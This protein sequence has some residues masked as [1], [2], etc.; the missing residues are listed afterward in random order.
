MLSRGSTFQ[1]SLNY[2]CISGRGTFVPKLLLNFWRGV[3][4][5]QNSAL[6]ESMFLTLWKKY[7]KLACVFFCRITTT[8]NLFGNNISKCSEC[9]KVLAS[10]ENTYQNQNNFE[11]IKKLE[12]VSRFLIPQPPNV[13]PHMNIMIAVAIL[14]PTWSWFAK[15]LVDETVG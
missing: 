2:C 7:S 11:K 15:R 9:L 14:A 1:N 6:L 4:P 13:P 10:R 5:L 12:S 8:D 3:T